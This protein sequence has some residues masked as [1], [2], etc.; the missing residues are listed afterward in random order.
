MRGA[1]M[2]RIVVA[3]VLI[4][5]VALVPATVQAAPTGHLN[6]SPSSSV[7]HHTSTLSL[8]SLVWQLRDIAAS[9][10]SMA[11]ASIEVNGVHGS[12]GASIEVNGAKS[13]AGAS[14]EVN[15]VHSDAG[16]S[17]EVNG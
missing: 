17:I 12:A 7:N 15:G 2:R 14:I 8:D 5:A 6:G 4:A 11:G 10:W 1:T 9:L 3:G 13:Q 16:A